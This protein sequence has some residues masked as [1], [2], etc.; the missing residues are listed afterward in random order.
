MCFAGWLYEVMDLLFI[1]TVGSVLKYK[2][3]FTN[4]YFCDVVIM[5]VVIPFLQILNDEDT[6]DIIYQDSWLHGLKFMFGL[7]KPRPANDTPNGHENG[8][9]RN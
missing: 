4:T 1:I 7:Y 6:K 5:F 9:N 3:G 8:N 2:Y